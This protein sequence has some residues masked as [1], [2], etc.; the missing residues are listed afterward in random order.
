MVFL[1]SMIYNTYKCTTK[2]EHC[3]INIANTKKVF[4]LESETIRLAKEIGYKHE[5]TLKMELS[6]ISGK[7]VK[8]EPIFIFKK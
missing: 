4:N 7:G 1:K 2:N 8:Y 3:L 6:S 5:N